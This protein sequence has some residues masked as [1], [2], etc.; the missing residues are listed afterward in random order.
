M[1]LQR[2]WYREIHSSASETTINILKPVRPP[3]AIDCLYEGSGQ[4]KDNYA[5][6]IV[7]I[8]DSI[9]MRWAVDI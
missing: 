5:H 4:D 1:N 6:Q 9:Q 3:T 7:E 2:L 8:S